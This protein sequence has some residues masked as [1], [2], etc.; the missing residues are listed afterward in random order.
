MVALVNALEKA[1]GI[2]IRAADLTLENFDSVNRIASYLNR[3]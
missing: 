1:Y 3:E 2:R